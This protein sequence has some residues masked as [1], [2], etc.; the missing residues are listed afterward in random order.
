[1]IDLDLQSYFDNVRHHLV[2]EKI[3][4]RVDDDAMMCLLKMIMKS[5]GKR[6][7]PQGGVLA[8]PTQ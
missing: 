5:T 3:A 4:K 2:L 8:P 6:G 1:M 7:V